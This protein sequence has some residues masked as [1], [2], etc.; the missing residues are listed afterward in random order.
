MLNALNLLFDNVRCACDAANKTQPRTNLHVKV[1]LWLHAHL[2]LREKRPTA[3]THAQC[4]V[5]IQLPTQTRRR[6]RSRTKR[7]PSKNTRILQPSTHHL[8]SA[9]YTA[10]R[11]LVVRTKTH[12]HT[13]MQHSIYFVYA[14]TRSRRAICAIALRERGALLFSVSL[15]HLGRPSTSSSP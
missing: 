15:V 8:I 7:K 10:V 11:S 13:R 12:T 3:L 4:S 14:C 9:C 6:H 5:H 2:M 1:S